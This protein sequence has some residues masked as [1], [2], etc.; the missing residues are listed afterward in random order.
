MKGKDT[1]NHFILILSMMMVFLYCNNDGY[2]QSSGNYTSSEIVYYSVDDFGYQIP[3]LNKVISLEIEDL[4]VADALIKIAVKAGLGIAFDPLLLDSY[5]NISI[6]EERI[7]VADALVQ[8]LAGTGYES[9]ITSHREILLQKKPG[10]INPEPVNVQTEIEGRVTDAQTGEPLPGVNVVAEG[11]TIG[12]STDT[13]GRYIIE[14]PDDTEVL[15]FT[16][17]GFEEQ[18]IPINGRT[19]I[20]VELS[21]S[22]QLLDDV[23]VTSFGIEQE[24]K[25][26]GYSIQEVSGEDIAETR[27]SNLV[28]SLQGR[29]AGVNIQNTS[30][31]AG[32]GVDI[33]IRG[34]NSLSPSADNQPLF[35][36]DGIPVSNQTNAGNVLPS[37]GSNSPGS[38]EQF[39]FTNRVADINPNDIESLSIL[40]GPAA[41]ALYGLRAANG[42]VVITTK[43]GQAGKPQVSL[44]TSIGFSEINKTPDIQRDF[45]G[46]RFGALPLTVFNFEFWQLGPPVTPSGEPIFDNFEN[47]FR[48]AVNATNEFSVSGGSESTTYFTSFSNVNNQGIVPNT[49]WSRTTFKLSGTQQVNQNFDVSGSLTYS[50]SGGTRPTG[51][52][53]SIM[54]SLSFWVPS[55]DINDFRNPDGSQKNPTTG[56]IDNPRFFVENS[57]LEDDVDRIIGIAGLNYQF[58]DWLSAEYQIGI[59]NFSDRRERFVPPNL[60]VGT[61]V[62]GFLIEENINYREINSNAFLRAEYSLTD[63]IRGSVL[64]GNQITDID[65]KTVNTRGE[66]LNIPNFRSLAN[67]TNIFTTESAFIRRLIGVFMDAR[68]EYDG[69]YFL[70]VTGRNDWSSTLPEDNRSFFYPSVNLSYVFTETL[71]LADSNIMPFGKLRF[72]WARVGK[73]APPFSVGQTFQSAPGFPFGSTGGFTQ[74]LQAG[75]TD[76]EPET[77]TTFEFGAEARLLGN[78][79]SLDITYFTQT[80]RDQIV[81]FPVSNATGLSR[82]TTNAGQIDTDGIELLVEGTPV[83]NRDFNW[84]VALNWSKFTSD[85]VSMPEGLDVIEFAN[86]GFAGVVSRIQ[87]GGELGDLFGFTF[88]YDDQGRLLIAD[89]GFPTIRTDTLVKVGN[90]FPDWQAGLTNTFNYKNIS[91]SFLLEFKQGGQAFDASLRNSIRNGIVALTGVR[92]EE[93]IFNGVNADGTPNDIP[94]EIDENFFRS[95]TRF[96]RAS[97]IIVQDA[98]WIRLRN[99]RIAY[100]LPTSLIDKLPLSSATF[101]VTGRNLFVTTPF[102]G[103]DPEGQQFSAGSNAFGF[104]GLNIPPTRSVTFSLNLRF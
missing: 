27:E 102:R 100:S 77:N 74:D 55:N 101:S 8:A 23:V 96:N 54:S 38:S 16:F 49:D 25:Q 7:K 68:I 69:T 71:G 56:I 80:S 82:F 48:T 89:D 30:G 94:V 15:V 46:G 60:D 81:A 78:R 3:E 75:A 2:S 10:F 24:R 20:N 12:T 17:I 72:S 97:E 53:K 31:A 26:L 93:V 44:T 6:V 63:K 95:S 62:N 14:V 42:A 43:K 79:A 83:R 59:D 64:L 9:V 88:D 50:N 66:G 11:T 84:N 36:I 86:S 99:A 19:E 103:Y 45:Q 104:T 90:A 41:T 21:T 5:R 76:L 22:V 4:P 98:D 87:E 35:V 18:R 39:S 52:D 1:K 67:T 34:I 29:V 92:N 13:D 57:T 28:S 73:D 58:N 51:G 40:K 85:V 33:V 70:S 47:F 65:S 37:E 32:A 61:Q 91:L